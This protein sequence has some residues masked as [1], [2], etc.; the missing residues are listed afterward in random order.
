VHLP[1]SPYLFWDTSID[2]LDAKQHKQFIIERVMSR[3]LLLDFY[4]LLKLY[5]HDELKEAL[6][7]IKG[8]DKKTINFCSRYF[9]IPITE[10]H[11]SSYYD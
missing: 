7:Q 4:Y 3:G 10:L 2:K 8:L 1:F 5:T 11:A 9:N 6:K